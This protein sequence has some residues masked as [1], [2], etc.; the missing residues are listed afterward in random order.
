MVCHIFF[1]N[2]VLLYLFENLAFLWNC[3]W[4]NLALL[5]S[6][7]WQP[8][9]QIQ[10]TTYVFGCILLLSEMD[11]NQNIAPNSKLSLITTFLLPQGAFDI[12]VLAV[13]KLNIIHLKDFHC[14]SLYLFLF[15]FL[16][17]NFWSHICV[18]C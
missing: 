9:L 17:R 16:R 4:T 10:I 18:N 12:C 7:T 2:L 6:G 14:C 8:W 5:F 13:S 1:K 11:Q 15:H 3:S